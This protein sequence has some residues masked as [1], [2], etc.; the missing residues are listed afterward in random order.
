VK[1]PQPPKPQTAAKPATE[2]ILIDFQR[3]FIT[4]SRESAADGLLIVPAVDA[5]FVPEPPEQERQALLAALEE[6]VGQTHGDAW[7]EA[8]LR[9][10]TETEDP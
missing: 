7:R 4:R 1:H 3:A 6:A 5:V 10:G 8:A 9:E 2:R